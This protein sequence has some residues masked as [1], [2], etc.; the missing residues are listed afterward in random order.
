MK[1]YMLKIVYEIK[2]LKLTMLLTLLSLF[3]KLTINI[4]KKNYIRNKL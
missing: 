4:N 3:I 2:N 1:K